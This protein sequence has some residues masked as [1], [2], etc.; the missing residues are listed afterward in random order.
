MTN[1]RHLAPNHAGVLA[2][3]GI[4]EHVIEARGYRTVEVRAELDRLGF[5]R[6][7]QIVP[8]LLIPVDG[9]ASG[10][11]SYQH[12]PDTPRTG[13]RGKPIK[14]ETPRGMRMALDVPPTARAH[15]GNPLVPLFVTEGIK[16]ADAAVSCG[17]CCIAL[18]GVWNWRGRNEDGGLTALGD[19]ESI[20][21][22]DRIV[23]V[24]FD[25]D[26]KTKPPVRAAMSRL[27]EFLASRGAIVS[28]IDLPSG[29]GGRK[30]GLDDFLVAGHS[31]DDLMALATPESQRA[32]PSRSRGT[33]R[34]H[35]ASST[36]SAALTV[37]SKCR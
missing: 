17:L 23:A 3:S 29:E 5:G 8:T 12:R 27:K 4:A 32:D 34:R 7:Q 30:V 1:A 25:S 19:W 22:K 26:V 10:I 18:L 15:I 21:L 37:S 14:Y 28:L 2:A 13:D 11:T 33:A 31:R 35:K 6:R 36:A 9:V 20:A 16:K 24:V